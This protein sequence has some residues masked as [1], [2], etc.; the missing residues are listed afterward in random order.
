MAKPR[1]CFLVDS[2]E[3]ETIPV[4]RLIRDHG[5]T[6]YAYLIILRAL[7]RRSETL[8]L[9]VTDLELFVP[10]FRADVEKL[11]SVIATMIKEKLILIIDQHYIDP[12]IVA[13]AEK[14]EKK[15]TLTKERV[16]RYRNVT[17]REKPSSSSSSSSK[18]LDLKKELSHP[19]RKPHGRD[20]LVFLTDAEHE[21]LI[22]RFG[23]TFA[24]RCIEKLDGWIAQDPTPKRIRNGKNGA[25]TLRSW[26]IAAVTEEQ[27]KAEKIKSNGAMNK[28]ERDLQKIRDM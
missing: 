9:R 4:Q 12:Y 23:S 19:D 21:S 22:E 27:A 28:L 3:F 13:D 14:Y 20:G 7:L 1:V 5:A 6:G 16:T 17:K 24:A 2:Y 18:I 10:H 25:A 15:R 8:S 26:V 11:Q